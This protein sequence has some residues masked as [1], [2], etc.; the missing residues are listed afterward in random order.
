MNKDLL[1]QGLTIVAVLVTLVMNGLANALPFNGQTTAQVSDK[2]PVFFVPAGYVFAIWGVIYLGLIAFAVYQALPRQ[3]TNPY[4]RRIGWWFILSC[5]A[6]SIWIVLWHY[7]RFALT[8]LFML[9]LLVSLI[10]VYVI[11]DIGRRR[12][13]ALETWCVDIPF[14]VYLGWISVA[15]VANITDFLYSTGWNGSPL[16]AETWAVIMLVAV[17]II[18]CAMI[19]TR[20]DIAF[21]LVIMWAAIGIAVKQG[22]TASVADAAWALAIAVAAVLIATLLLPRFRQPAASTRP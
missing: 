7:E 3:R 9:T 17:L 5:A 21:S 15:T 8:V 1:R 20:R 4:L 6:N 2:F 22:A 12:V 14:S 10:A 11:L 16:A 19:V 18:T 13:S